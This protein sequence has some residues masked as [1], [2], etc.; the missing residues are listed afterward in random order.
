MRRICMGT[1][2]L[3]LCVFLLN[4]C[5]RSVNDGFRISLSTG[6]EY[7]LNEDEVEK[8]NFKTLNDDY[9]RNLMPLVKNGRGFIWLKKAFVLDGKNLNEPL[10]IYLGRITLADRTFLNGNYMGGEGSFP[11][12]EFSAWNTARY[13][14][15]PTGLLREGENILLVKIWVHGE[16]SIVSNP[17]IGKDSDARKAFARENFW[18]SRL[19]F[20]FA[21]LMLIISGYHFMIWVKSRAERENLI[22]ALINMLSVFY[23]SVFFYSDLPFEIGDYMSFLVFQKIFSS[24]LPFVF[25]FL[26]ALFIKSFLKENHHRWVFYLQLTFLVIP[27]GIVMLTPSYCVLR[28]MRWI[29]I[30]LLP[31][32]FYIIFLLCRA[33]LKGKKDAKI[34]LWGFSPLVG[35]VLMDL[36]IHEVFSIYDFPY[37]SSLGW[38]VV[39]VVFLFIMAN[40]FVNSKQQV[41]DLNKNLESKVE[42]RTE[43][44]KEANEKLSFVN[45]A[46]EEKNGLLA[47][48]QKKTERDMKLAV[49]V[50]KSFYNEMTPK[51]KDWDVAYY[52]KPAAGVSGD[53]YDFFYEG[54]I[55]QGVG[56]FDV[57][58]HGIAAGLVTMLA[59]AV[60]DRKFKEGTSKPFGQ[61][62][63]EING[64]LTAEKGDIENYLT[65]VLMRMDGNKVKLINAGHPAVFFRNSRNGKVAPI[66][67]KNGESSNGIIGVKDLNPDFK[68]IKFNMQKDDCIFLYTDCLN[69]SRNLQG[70]EYG[71]ERIK[72]A[73]TLSPIRDSKLILDYIIKDFM[74]FIGEGEVKDDLTAI[75]LRFKGD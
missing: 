57:S 41:E 21:F 9:L 30:F 56:L 15:I 66:A 67:L 73:L 69:E 62:F 19:N 11:P 10:S 27:V 6:W 32:L 48:A 60:I 52:F 8:G 47:E 50:Q 44:L 2:G 45:S 22:F 49:S 28:A 59:K 38:Q 14:R 63:S 43:S 26:I 58:G 33:M 39:I 7:A 36:L 23:L 70:T 51:L 54:D 74:N 53:L 18:N 34:L 55:L 75:V 3:L 5:Q 40:R 13:Y 4:G 17:F 29:Q 71:F 46:L 61:L 12:G 64:Q 42:K 68:T 37:L 65:G 1:V 20:L 24:G 35:F 16:G 72:Q 31:P 25:P